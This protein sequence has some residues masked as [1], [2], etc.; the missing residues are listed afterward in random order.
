MCECLVTT[1]QPQA[2][3]TNQGSG[4]FL[5]GRLWAL[6]HVPA[7]RW[8]GRV[9]TVLWGWGEWKVKGCRRPPGLDSTPA[10]A[11]A[12]P[13]QGEALGWPASGD[14][15]CPL[16]TWSEHVSQGQQA[17][18]DQNQ[19]HRPEVSGEPGGPSPGT[20]EA[21]RVNEAE[22]SGREMQ[23]W[24]RGSPSQRPGGLSSCPGSS[25][26]AHPSPRRC[27]PST[28]ARARDRA[29]HPRMPRAPPAHQ[30]W[31]PPAS[32]RGAQRGIEGH[33]LASAS[34]RVPP[35]PP[36]DANFQLGLGA[37][38]TGDS[39]GAEAASP[40]LTGHLGPTWARPRPRGEAIRSSA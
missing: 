37:L 40:E 25:R 9:Q 2:A 27:V 12:Q 3:G 23:P 15:S 17:R 7:C 31:C 20:R 4:T 14:P 5:A 21:S 19:G 32:S 29:G 38:P 34:P 22:Q 6:G 10:P 26:M 35:P 28:Q 36:E 11:P 13:L 1:G 16:Q 24:P 8:G 18:Q 39:P 30:L 33:Q